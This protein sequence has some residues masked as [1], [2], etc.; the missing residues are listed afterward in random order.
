MRLLRCYLDATPRLPNPHTPDRSSQ[1]ESRSG[2]RGSGG[3]WRSGPSEADDLLREDRAEVVAH[4]GGH[5]EDGVAGGAQSIGE[6]EDDGIWRH[7][8]PF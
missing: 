2:L 8:G 5:G 4:R 6:G 7:E 1:R 3:G